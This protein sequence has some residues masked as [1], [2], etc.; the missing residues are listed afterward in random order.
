M[1]TSVSR[2]YRYHA[3]AADC[4]LGVD[5]QIHEYLV[6][7]ASVGKSYAGNLAEAGLEFNIFPDRPAEDA[8]ESGSGRDRPR[9]A[10]LW[11]P[12]PFTAKNG[13]AAERS[14]H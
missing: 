4:I 14:R 10:H 11:N 2:L 7:L 5:N 1:I 9:P 13:R 3:V 6:K 12:S 8:K